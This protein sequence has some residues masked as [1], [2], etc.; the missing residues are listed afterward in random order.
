MMMAFCLDQSQNKNGTMQMTITG[1]SN[2]EKKLEAPQPMILAA[3]MLRIPGFDFM[4]RINSE[5]VH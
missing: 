1:S 5:Q 3:T 2:L 4:Q